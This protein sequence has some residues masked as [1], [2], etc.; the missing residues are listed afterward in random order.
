LLS[1]K[2]FIELKDFNLFFLFF[3]YDIIRRKK[4]RQMWGISKNRM[5]L[6]VPSLIGKVCPTRC[7][8]I[9]PKKLEQVFTIF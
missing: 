7:P 3:S 2:D 4:R 8:P 6:R 1:A 5:F 9:T